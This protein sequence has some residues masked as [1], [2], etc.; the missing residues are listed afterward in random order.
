MAL[1]RHLHLPSAH[2]HYIP[3]ALANRVQEHLRRGHLDFKDAVSSTSPIRQAREPPPPTLVTFTP[4]PIYTLG[5]RQ[6]GPLP[7]A[8][9]ARLTAPLR[10]PSPSQTGRNDHETAAT[11]TPQVLPSPR[12]GLTTYHGP[13][14]V[15]LWPVLDL[16]SPLHK[17]FTV[18]CY[19]RLL[20]N[21]TIAVLASVFGIRAGT[22]EDPGVWAAASSGRE[23]DARKI[24]A[25]G[26]HLRRHVAALGTA[27]NLAMPGPEVT[28]EG[29][30]PWARIVACGL[31]GKGVTSVAGEVGGGGAR[32]RVMQMLEA[33]MVSGKDGP[34][35]GMEEATARLWAGEFSQRI[36]LGEGV[37]VVERG[38]AVRLM[39]R[40]VREGDEEGGE[41]APEQEEREY[42][43]RLGTG[44]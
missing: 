12:G 5:R 7:A 30:N 9:I 16:K 13:G 18:K 35:L 27:L 26:V 10:I 15:V 36:G 6:T 39:E 40:L 21:T 3:Y 14:Q 33:K 42:L 11:L 23:E 19:A 2:P 4:S 38:E 25:L 8:T 43:A 32:G 31:E 1:L 22:T 20:E 37:E 41:A 34:V 29:L 28:D 17:N 44:R 24:A